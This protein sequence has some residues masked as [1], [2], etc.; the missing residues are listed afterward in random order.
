MNRLKDIRQGKGI[1]ISKLSRDSNVSR[2]SIYRL[3]NEKVN[4]ANLKTLTALA[5]ALSV[6]VS[7]FF[8]E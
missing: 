1:S 8:V 6:K 4:T 5:D 2:Q 3:E 7:D